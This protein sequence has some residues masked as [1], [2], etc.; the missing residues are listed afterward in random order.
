MSKT[1]KETHPLIW[2]QSGTLREWN[3][4]AESESILLVP[5]DA[6]QE[7]TIEKEFIKNVLVK[8][9]KRIREID[10]GCWAEDKL[11]DSDKTL[12]EL[13]TALGLK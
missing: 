10:E 12:F 4:G 1:L 8:L 13:E 5:A 11:F 3:R 2:T 7:H 6:V 9:K